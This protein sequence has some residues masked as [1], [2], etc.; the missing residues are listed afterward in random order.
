MLY[1][2]ACDGIMVQVPLPMCLRDEDLDGRTVELPERIPIAGSGHGFPRGSGRPA[3]A[4]RVRRGVPAGPPTPGDRL[5]TRRH[6]RARQTRV[7]SS[8]CGRSAT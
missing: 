7:M 2:L 6:F 5:L 1:F 8:N 4:G 3:A